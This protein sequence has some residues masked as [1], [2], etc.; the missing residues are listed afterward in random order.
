MEKNDLDLALVPLGLALMVGYHLW[1]LHHVIHH[2]TKT[3]MGINAI[4]RR[5]WVE[6]IMEVIN[7]QSFLITL[8]TLI[9][10]FETV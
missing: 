4:N 3:V 8:F 6:T 10:I 1:L 5:I 7:F 2:P 9:S